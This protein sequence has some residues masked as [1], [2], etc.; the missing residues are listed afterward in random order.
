MLTKK[1][2]TLF[3]L[4][5]LSAALCLSAGLLISAQSGN[6]DITANDLARLFR[7][8]GEIYYALFKNNHIEIS[9]SKRAVQ[10]NYLVDGSG[11]GIISSCISDLDGDDTDEILLIVGEEGSEF[12]TELQILKTET[13]VDEK[14]SG[15]HDNTEA[16]NNKVIMRIAY[17]KDM[18]YINPWK[19]QTCDVDGDGKTEISIGVYKTTR[20]HPVMAK[21]PFIYEWH[22]DAIAPKWLGSRLSRPFDDYI[23]ADINA[24]NTDELISIER[25]KNG[26]KAVNSYAWKGFGFESTGESRAYEDIRNIEEGG[27]GTEGKQVI[28]ACVVIGGREHRLKLFYSDGKFIDKEEGLH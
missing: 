15:I 16:G 7:V 21:R 4:K 13:A 22:G 5:L 11:T 28:D 14:L 20:F 27:T 2:K 19:V 6:D 3:S 18:S 9:D 25:L 26:G 24:D 8:D 23:F 12:G 1:T 17:K 10:F